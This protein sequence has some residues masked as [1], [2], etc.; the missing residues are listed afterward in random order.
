MSTVSLPHHSP[1]VKHH[2]R[3]LASFSAPDPAEIVDLWR[4]SV[5]LESIAPAG[6]RGGVARRR[7]RLLAGV[8]SWRLPEFLDQL[9]E[10][11]V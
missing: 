10:A 3:N 7:T 11:I 2:Q 8:P 5:T 4:E 6:L 9:S 1:K